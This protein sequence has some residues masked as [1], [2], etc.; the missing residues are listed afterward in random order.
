MT[1]EGRA[2]AVIWRVMPTPA[3]ALLGLFYLLLDLLL[4]RPLRA[5]RAWLGM[6]EELER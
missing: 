2:L 1:D 6:P 5:L 4:E 3:L